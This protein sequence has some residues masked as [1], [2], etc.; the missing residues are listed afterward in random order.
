MSELRATLPALVV[1]RGVALIIILLTEG[2]VFHAGDK[3]Y[4]SML[5]V[6]ITEPQKVGTDDVVERWNA[7]V[8]ALQGRAEVPRPQKRF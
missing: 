3:R 1:Y 8:R 7:K 6:G 4:R 2:E 5:E